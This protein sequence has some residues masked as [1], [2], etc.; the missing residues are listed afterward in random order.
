MF[1]CLYLNNNQIILHFVVCST[2]IL[3]CFMIETNSYFKLFSTSLSKSKWKVFVPCVITN[4]L[5][6]VCS[7][8]IIKTWL[9]YGKAFWWFS[10]VDIKD[11]VWFN[12]LMCMSYFQFLFV[13]II[14]KF[15]LI[16]CLELILL[17]LNLLLLLLHHP[18]VVAWV[19][20][21]LILWHQIILLFYRLIQTIHNNYSLQEDFF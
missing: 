19:V 16:V 12:V 18:P 3:L 15:W 14:L 1:P 11:R 10:C 5:S 2:K 13:L 21:H 9:Y 7:P 17:I 8:I 6:P 4:L 20:Y